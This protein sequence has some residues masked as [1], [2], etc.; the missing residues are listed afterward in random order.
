M[1]STLIKYSVLPVRCARNLL[2]LLSEEYVMNLSL[3]LTIQVDCSVL[4]TTVRSMSIPLSFCHWKVINPATRKG[5]LES[6]L[7][8]QYWQRIEETQTGCWMP[9]G[10]SSRDHLHEQEEPALQTKHMQKA[11]PPGNE[12]LSQRKGHIDPTWGVMSTRFIK[13]VGL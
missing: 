13:K 10:A 9:E 5:I 3:L 1:G 12:W 8:S 4:Q 7:T 11:S 6:V 2:G